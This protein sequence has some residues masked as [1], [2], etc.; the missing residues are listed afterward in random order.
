VGT[1]LTQ[2]LG[3]KGVDRSALDSLGSRPQLSLQPRRDFARCLVGEGEY[4]DAFRIE[5]ALLD[6]ESNP[7]DQAE[8]LSRPGAGENQDRLGECLDGLALRVAGDLGRVRRDRRGYGDDRVR[9]GKAGDGS[10]QVMFGL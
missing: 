2:Q 8:C 9:S 10:G 3:A 7:L 1:E 6:Q 4:A 5:R